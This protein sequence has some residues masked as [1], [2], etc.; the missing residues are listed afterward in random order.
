MEEEVIE[1]FFKEQL[2]ELRGLDGPRLD[3]RALELPLARIKRQCTL[4]GVPIL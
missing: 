3:I 2:A 4:L 1:R